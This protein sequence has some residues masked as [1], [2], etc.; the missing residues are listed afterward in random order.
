M[1]KAYLKALDA[2]KVLL[3]MQMDR[4]LRLEI[5]NT[6]VLTAQRDS[7]CTQQITKLA[8]VLYAAISSQD[9]PE[10]LELLWKEDSIWREYY[11]FQA[12]A[13]EGPEHINIRKVF[14]KK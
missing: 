13:S 1:L 5:V 6:P 12:T 11:F 7:L 9:R 2:E 4:N 10:A 3:R 14:P 8:R